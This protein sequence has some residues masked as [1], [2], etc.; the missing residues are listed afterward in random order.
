MRWLWLVRRVR[1]QGTSSTEQE[2]LGVRKALPVPHFVPHQ[3]TRKSTCQPGPMGTNEPG[4]ER[5]AM[6]R[7]GYEPDAVTVRKA[8]D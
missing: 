7:R 6:Y 8:W 1:G 4:A 3:E 5:A 2:V